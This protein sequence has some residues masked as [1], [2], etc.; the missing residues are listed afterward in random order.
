MVFNIEF[1][2]NYSLMLLSLISEY[3]FDINMKY[4]HAGMDYCLAAAAVS[5]GQRSAIKTHMGGV[6]P[7]HTRTT[8]ETGCFSS[9]DNSHYVFEFTI[10]RLKFQPFTPR[11]AITVNSKSYLL[12]G[13]IL[14]PF[15]EFTFLKQI[16]M[17]ARKQR[18]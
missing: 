11:S 16:F 8:E 9:G 6:S 14:C 18:I 13:F 17:D 10:M 5:R 12:N 3:C 2:L 4:M 1:Q 7:V 15:I